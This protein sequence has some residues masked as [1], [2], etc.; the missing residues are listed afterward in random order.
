MSELQAANARENS[1][2]AARERHQCTIQAIDWDLAVA[3][4]R[5]MLDDME[6]A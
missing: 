2:K 5:K 6:N 3:R 4:L 1:A